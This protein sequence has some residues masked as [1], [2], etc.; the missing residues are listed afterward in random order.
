VTVGAQVPDQP[1]SGRGDYQVYCASCHGA[2]AR[3]DGVIAKSQKKRPSDLTQLSNRNSGTFPHEKVVKF[4][5][6][7]E[8]GRAHSDSDMPAWGDVFARSSDS[9]GAERA[10]ARIDVLVKYLQ[11][12]QAK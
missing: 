12:L 5:D 10:A 6:G 7:R 2:D 4:V 8:A 11:T 1:Y 9:I 3:G